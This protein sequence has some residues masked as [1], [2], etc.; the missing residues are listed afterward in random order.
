MVFRVFGHF[1]FASSE[2]AENHSERFRVVDSDDRVTGN[3]FWEGMSV[4]EHEI[5]LN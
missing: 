2:V 3:E 5:D 1:T 4:G